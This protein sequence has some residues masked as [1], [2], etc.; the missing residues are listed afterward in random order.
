M[1][2]YRNRNSHFNPFAMLLSI[3]DQLPAE[4]EAERKARLAREAHELALKTCGRRKWSTSTLHCGKDSKSQT[5][6][7]RANNEAKVK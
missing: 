3:R 6:I 1:A 2:N 4:T 5:A 7:D